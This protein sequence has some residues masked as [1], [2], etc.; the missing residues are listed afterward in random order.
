MIIQDLRAESYCRKLRGIFGCLDKKMI[1]EEEANALV[2]LLNDR[3][4][5]DARRICDFASAACDVLGIESYAG[6]NEY[7]IRMIGELKES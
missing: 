4:K 7:V 2:E 5:V 3:Q 6:N 1:T